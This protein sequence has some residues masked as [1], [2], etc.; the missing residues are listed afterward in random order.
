MFKFLAL[1]IVKATVTLFYRF[2]NNK[3]ST[4]WLLR[5]FGRIRRIRLLRRTRIG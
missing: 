5:R 3:I 2:L 4:H 1:E